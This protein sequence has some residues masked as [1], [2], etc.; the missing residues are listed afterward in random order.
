MSLSSKNSDY[1]RTWG[2]VS[3]G[4]SGKSSGSS[5]SSSRSRGG[6]G[7][8]GTG[9]YVGGWEVTQNPDGS[10]NVP[11]I[12]TVGGGGGGGGSSR[13]SLTPSYSGLGGS[14]S[15][16]PI[17]FGA[18]TP[19][20]AA[21]PNPYSAPELA[22]I[23]YSVDE[24]GNIVAQPNEVTSTTRTKSSPWPESGVDNN[25]YFDG[26]G[27]AYTDKYGVPHVV[28]DYA[29]AAE[30]ARD[31]TGTR[32]PWTSLGGGTYN[33]FTDPGSVSAYRG[34]YS[35]GYAIDRDNNRVKVPL[36]GAT[37]FG[38][39]RGE[40]AG[41]EGQSLAPTTPTT[42]VRPPDPPFF[43]GS[44]W[45][46]GDIDIDAELRAIGYDPATMSDTQKSAVLAAIRQLRGGR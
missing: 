26:V 13:K 21:A 9:Q 35:G 19:Y 38:G 46:D 7:A 43:E 27:Y 3:S 39:G 29:T 28:N 16:S 42:V 18:N 6:G 34:P 2:T 11:G 32:G 5:G 15:D 23:M 33:V 12:G 45:G 4:S 22:P 30:Y 44:V 8:K 41:V 10:F 25:N 20:S 1:G 37:A 24:A 17:D 31:A 36:P 14:F 40:R